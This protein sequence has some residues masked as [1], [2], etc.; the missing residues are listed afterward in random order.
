MALAQVAVERNLPPPVARHGA[1]LQLG[2][3][4]FAG[5]T[6]ETPLGANL[7]GVHV[8]G[9]KEK[10]RATP[11][12]VVGDIGPLDHQRVA[13]A[14]APFIGQPI[15]RKLISQVQA[16][17]ARV[18]REAGYPFVSVTLPP[19]DASR[20]LLQVR[21]V[22]FH[23]G[24]VKVDGAG[25]D[26]KLA[27]RI[28]LAPGERIEAAKLEEDL[29]WINRN[30]YRTAQGVFAPGLGVGASDFTLK[31]SD[32]KPWQVFG[33][34]SDTGQKATG[35]DRYFIGAG[36]LIAPFNDAVVSYQFTGSSDFWDD[37]GFD[38]G[39]DAARYVS[40]SARIVIPTFARQALE[41]S[42]DYIVTRQNQDAYVAFNNTIFEL[43]IIYR[44]AVSN[45]LPG[46]Y[47][48]DVYGGAEFKQAERKTYFDQ[49][50]IGH[51]EADVFQL[52]FGWA[53][54]FSD[55]WGETSLNARVKV[56]PGH[57]LDDNTDAAW[58]LFS[59][60]RVTSVDYAYGQI[61]ANRVT[62]L[63]AGFS[64]VVQASALVA[65]QALPDTEQLALGGLDAVR[66]YTLDDGAVD[67]G[68]FWRNDLRA[69]A[70]SLAGAPAPSEVSP[71]AFFDFAAGRTFNSALPRTTEMASLGAGADLRVGSY[72]NATLIGAYA[73]RD[74]RDDLPATVTGT[75]SGDWTVQARVT[76]SY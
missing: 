66:G 31:V 1:G 6:D 35:Y 11:G 22:E 23:A 27:D 67:Q 16:A 25:D 76:L 39:V 44:S 36:A 37:R 61:D 32:G 10:P 3:D 26:A 51:G 62:K 65:D 70:I 28:R 24:K 7:V 34:Y 5:S 59:S 73:L 2:A 30:P 53:D 68:F 38:G 58:S 4:N 42:P 19:H 69:P 63:P 48:G 74:A 46:L 57:V 55:A 18:Y 71:Y 20:G 45:L 47:L 8:L 15:S 49:I 54:H 21:V 56:N 75:R 40:H 17:I 72:V 64:W 9:P 12:V 29:D 60:G 43:P 52:V 41:I 50:D 33:G 14:V 13:D